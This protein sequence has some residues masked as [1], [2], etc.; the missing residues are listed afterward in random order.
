MQKGS[1]SGEPFIR[2]GSLFSLG[3]QSV[4]MVNPIGFEEVD[5]KHDTAQSP[6]DGV[7]PGYGG[8]FV[9]KLD[10]HSNVGNPEKT[11]ACQHSKHR[12]SGLACAPHN[13]GNTMGKRHQTVKQ[14]N[15][16]HMPGAE[17]DGLRRVAE[18]T[19]QLWREQIGEYTDQFCHD[20]AAGNT[21]AH[22]LFHPLMLPGTQILPHKGGQGLGKAGDRKKSKTFQLGVRATAC[23]GGFAETVDIGL[24]YHIGKGD[25]AVLHTGG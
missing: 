21:K 15:G 24:H 13:A 3:F 17:I 9:D 5:Q 7:G 16:S 19:N 8:Q 14:A 1:P 11:P 4:K 25:D 6:G 10:C 22:T 18:Q 2:W 20:A 12:H 23:H